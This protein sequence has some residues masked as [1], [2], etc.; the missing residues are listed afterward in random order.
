MPEAAAKA[1]KTQSPNAPGTFVDPCRG[2]YFKLIILGITEAHFTQC[3]G[4]EIKIDPISYVEGGSDV[5]HQIP[6][7]RV[8]GQRALSRNPGA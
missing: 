3:S 4:V 6:G 7:C 1:P 5:E 8:V 2:F